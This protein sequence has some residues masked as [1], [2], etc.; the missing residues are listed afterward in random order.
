MDKMLK[1]QCK[2]KLQ[3]CCSN[4]QAE[5]N[6]NF[7]VTGRTNIPFKPQHQNSSH[8]HRQQGDLSLSDKQFYTQPFNRRCTKQGSTTQDTELVDPLQMA[9][10]T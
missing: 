4:N 9:E 2:Y 10:G 7:E 8:L 1:K 3:N 5:H 6:R